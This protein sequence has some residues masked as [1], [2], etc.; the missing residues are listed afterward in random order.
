LPPGD[1]GAG[2]PIHIEGEI[3]NAPQKDIRGN[4]ASV[5]GIQKVFRLG[6]DQ[7]QGAN[8]VKGLV[9]H[10]HV[11]PFFGAAGFRL[12]HLVHDEPPGAPGKF[13]VAVLQIHLGDLEIHGWLLAGFIQ[14]VLQSAGFLRVGGVEA[15]PFF[16]EGVEGI[17]NAVFAAEDAVALFHG[18]V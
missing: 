12:A 15:V 2:N 5:H 8:L 7:G 9:L 4:R 3:V 13:R 6:F 17:V 16:G 18:S 1:D 14:G 10:R 11:P